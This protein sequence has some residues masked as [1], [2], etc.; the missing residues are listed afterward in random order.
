[1]KTRG[2]EKRNRIAPLTPVRANRLEAGVTLMEVAQR[3]GL[4]SFRVSIIE[5]DPSQAKPGEIDA[6]R[7]AVEYLGRKQRGAA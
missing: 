5:R 3:S 7:G 1:M 6:H 2:H 4:T